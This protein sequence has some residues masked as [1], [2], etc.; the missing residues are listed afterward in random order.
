MSDRRMATPYYKTSAEKDYAV[1]ATV[2][3]VLAFIT[4]AMLGAAMGYGW[5]LQ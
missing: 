2:T 5:A 4:G 3:V 1:A